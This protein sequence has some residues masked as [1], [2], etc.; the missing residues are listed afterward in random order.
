MNEL[1][2]M[3]EKSK[4]KIKQSVVVEI[5]VEIQGPLVGTGRIDHGQ[6]PDHQEFTTNL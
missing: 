1:K 3:Q 5:S 6:N 4:K 2:L